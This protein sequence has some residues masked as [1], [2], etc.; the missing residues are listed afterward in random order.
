MI[1][2]TDFEYPTQVGLPTY[3]E[4]AAHHEWFWCFD[5]ERAF[6]RADVR[7][8]QDGHGCAYHDCVG[9]PV[10]FWQWDAFRAFVGT[11]PAIPEPERRYPLAA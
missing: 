3:V 9:A 2:L 4:A 10:N 6:Q 11:G 7:G 8:N 5:C 1:N